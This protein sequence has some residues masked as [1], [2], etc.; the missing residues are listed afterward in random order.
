[1]TTYGFYFDAE[2][3]IGCHTCQIACKDA[4]DL[5]I[6]TNYRIVR[7][8][9]SGSGVTPHV[10][11]VSLSA[12]GCDLCSDLRAAGEPVACV[13]ACPMRCLEFGDMD[14]LAAKHAAEELVDGVPA[15]PHDEMAQPN[16]L[17]RIKE[18]MTDPDFDE[19]II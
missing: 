13:A 3:C 9:C 6:G 14:E 15:T 19:I 8:F 10:Y 1:M 18:C 16:I 2:N 11:H 12:Q 5:P 7:S 4:H 17:M